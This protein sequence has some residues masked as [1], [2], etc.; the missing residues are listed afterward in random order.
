M[1]LASYKG[2]DGS[3][4]A[5]V[6]VNRDGGDEVIDLNEASGGK[7]HHSLIHIIR[8]GDAALDQARQI[9]AGNAQGKPISSVQLVAPIP[10]PGKLICIAGN[11]Q[12][13]IE[14]G[15]GKRVDKNV[16]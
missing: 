5:A 13:H 9:A 7:L 2:P 15:G 16:I 1:R 8:E 10:K 6:V 4:R 11:F 3:A 12:K 14:E